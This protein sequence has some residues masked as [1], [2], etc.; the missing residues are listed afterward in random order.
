VIVGAETGTS[1]TVVYSTDGARTLTATAANGACPGTAGS[2][3]VTI[4]AGAAGVFADGFENGDM[5]AWSTVV[6]N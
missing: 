6:G 3:Q 2:A 4:V 5:A 1:V